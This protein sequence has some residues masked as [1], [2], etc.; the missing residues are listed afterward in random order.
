MIGTDWLSGSIA[1]QERWIDP[2]L[3]RF[4]TD[5][6]A[7]LLHDGGIALVVLL[8]VLMLCA[9]LRSRGHSVRGF[10]TR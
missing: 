8:T 2:L 1:V 10:G 3:G 9:E 5:A 7:R 6:L 4:A